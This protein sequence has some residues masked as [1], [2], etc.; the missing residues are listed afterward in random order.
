M[1]ATAMRALRRAASAP[2]GIPTPHCLLPTALAVSAL[3][4]LTTP[5]RAY[6]FRTGERRIGPV[7]YTHLRAHETSAHL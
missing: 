5:F 3:T 4:A 7:S 2:P 6:C 1:P